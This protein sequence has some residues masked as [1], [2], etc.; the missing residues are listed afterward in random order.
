M[1]S[2]IVNPLNRFTTT[3]IVNLLN[4]PKGIVKPVNQPTEINSVNLDLISDVDL[5]KLFKSELEANGYTV[6]QSGCIHTYYKQI[7]SFINIIPFNNGKGHCGSN[8]SNTYVYPVFYRSDEPRHIEKIGYYV[9][10][11]G[12]MEKSGITHLSLN[13]EG[14][15]GVRFILV[16]YELDSKSKRKKRNFFL[17]VYQLRIIK[18]NKIFGFLLIGKL[19]NTSLK[20][21]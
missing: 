19:I 18:K 9:N 15:E 11:R 13:S 12:V 6:S 7:N 21:L 10:E 17:N 4:T 5:P 2:G 14:T 8:A 20:Y 1:K 3:G 16:E